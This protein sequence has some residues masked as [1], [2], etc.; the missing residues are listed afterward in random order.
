[1]MNIL[2]SISYS[3]SLCLLTWCMVKFRNLAKH[4]IC[5]SCNWFWFCKVCKLSLILEMLL[6]LEYTPHP[7]IQVRIPTLLMHVRLLCEKGLTL[8]RAFKNSS[9]KFSSDGVSDWV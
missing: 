7:S 2:V 6:A 8:F 3:I 5:L 1:M 9:K 4:L